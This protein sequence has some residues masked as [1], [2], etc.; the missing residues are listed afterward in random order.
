MEPAPLDEASKLQVFRAALREERVKWS[1]DY[2]LTLK[3]GELRIFCHKAFLTHIQ[4]VAERIGVT[5]HSYH[6]YG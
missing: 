2:S 3:Y 4:E 5:V 6:T 1:V